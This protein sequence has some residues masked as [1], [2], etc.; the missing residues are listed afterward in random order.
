M[1]ETLNKMD[2]FAVDS[3]ESSPD[4][5]EDERQDVDK[6]M[7]TFN[8]YKKYRSRYDRRWLDYYKFFRGTQWGERKPRWRNSEIINLVW[9]TIQSQVP[10]QTDVRPKFSFLPSEPSDTKFAS[11]LEKIADSDWERHNWLRVVL[12][13]LYDGYIYGT[14]FSSM[15][16]DATLDF[17]VGAAVY[18]SE[19]PFYCFPCPESNIINDSES[20]GF[21]YARPIRTE[22]LRQLYPD[23]AG[24]IREDIKDFVRKER[25]NL[26]GF[27]ETYQNTDREMPEGTW[28]G[29]SEDSGDSFTFVVEGFLKPSE[30][31]EDEDSRQNQTSGEIEKTYTVR[32]KHP[33]GR[34]V[35]VAN[36]MLLLD[37][38]LPYDDNLIPFSKFNN[39][40]LSREFFGVSEIE[41]LE[42]PQ[43]IFNK[44][45]CFTLDAWA[46]TGNP[47]WVVDFNSGVDTD[48]GF[49]NVPGSIL[50]KNPGTEVRQIPGAGMNPAIMPVLDRLVGW[51]NTIA[52]Q[53]GELS[54]GDAPGG[55]TAAS[56]IEQLVK[57]ARTRVRQKQRN[58][59]EYLIDVGQQY[60]NR[61]FQFYTV[62]KIFRITND[63][64]STLFKK[65]RVD[66]DEKGN[67]VAV[68]SDY[69]Q[70]PKTGEMIEGPEEK[71]AIRGMFDI[72]V[73]TGSDLPFEEVDTER[74]T[75]ALFDRGIIDAE[76]VLDR[77]QYPNKERI[78]MRLQEQQQAAMAA[79]QQQG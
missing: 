69:T 68:M 43:R 12:E 36:G 63:D 65:F 15:R 52:G 60:M 76:E 29:S 45:L 42:G 6:I 22:K 19:D 9:Q 57:I 59:D 54:Q 77:L 58:L 16:Y 4:I 8:R 44:F 20:E 39:Y 25:T 56:A 13:I 40:V 62:P 27:Q 28:G 48:Q 3:G 78:L 2:D 1:L 64:G 66:R 21:F 46:L 33:N 10:L 11:V 30:L 32:K 37:E 53:S 49:V 75:L 34:H 14:S 47:I 26:S 18:K 79:Q 38:E 5:S 55:V 74:K 50:E 7:K 72:R 71:M 67:R 73:K 51:F 24:S 61:V 23:R 70:N 17:G 41:Q 31:V 35:V